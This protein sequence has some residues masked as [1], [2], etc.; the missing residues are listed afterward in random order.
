[1]FIYIFRM[2]KYIEL[3]KKQFD[4]L[5]GKEMEKSTFLNKKAGF[6]FGMQQ[7]SFNPAGIFSLKVPLKIYKGKKIRKI[8]KL[9][10]IIESP[11]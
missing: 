4:N 3:N 1:M 7:F 11:L 2:G 10:F 6:F 5:K 9:S 8:R